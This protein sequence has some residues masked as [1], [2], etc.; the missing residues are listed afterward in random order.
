MNKVYK[1]NTINAGIHIGKA[2]FLS[3]LSQIVPSHKVTAD[4]AAQE[5]NHLTA[6]LQKASAQIA[7]ILATLPSD[8]AEREIFDAH[9]MILHDPDLLARLEHLVHTDGY[10]SAQAIRTAF[11]EVIHTFNGMQNDFFAQRAADYK[12]LQ[13][14]ILVILLGDVADPLAAF[15]PSEVLFASETSPSLVIAMADKGIPAWVSQKGAYTSHAAILSRGLD[16]VALSSIHDLPDLVKDGDMVVVD[17]IEGKLIVAP[18]EETLRHYQQ[19]QQ[20]LQSADALDQA[21]ALKPAITQNGRTIKVLANIELPSE[22]AT[23]KDAGAEGIGLF[24]TEFLY[25]DQSSLPSQEQQYQHYLTVARQMAPHPVTIRTFDLGGDKLSHLIPSERED[26]PYLGC[27]GL[28]F[29]LSRKDIFKTQLK[30]VLRAALHG[31]LRLM[32]PM[33]NDV[34]DLRAA[35][36]L[37]QKCSEELTAEGTPHKADIPLGVMI[38]VPS[39][40]LC[41]QEL[42]QEADLFSLGT[43]DLAQ[44][45][46]AVDRNSD[47]LAKKYIQHHPAVIRLIAFTIAAAKGAGIPVAVCGEMSSIPK[48]I[49]LLVGMGIDELS[50]PPRRVARC[51]AIIRACDQALEDTLQ[52]TEPHNLTALE[53]LI[54]QD[55]KK[56]YQI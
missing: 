53:K 8:G 37:V 15:Q 40:A 18:D 3:S 13:Q 41:A 32:F 22:S 49:P 16:I 17:A 38:E 47:A 48:Y 20:R 30:A 12:D 10:N 11:E 4:E 35:R 14:R 2:R 55:F 36:E 39:A 5:F 45:T 31:Q 50:V 23:L 28:R 7:D 46:L 52:N 42:A 56:Y 9:Q 25:L 43:N 54:N 51:K 21:A 24:R 6:A 1:G 29:S 34:T 26:N 19:L 44:Y 27:R 33:V